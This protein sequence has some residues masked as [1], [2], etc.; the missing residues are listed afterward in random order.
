MRASKVV[1]VVVVVKGVVK[2]VCPP[3]TLGILSALAPGGQAPTAHNLKHVIGG[4]SASV[5]RIMS[6]WSVVARHA[7]VALSKVR[8]KFRT[9]ALEMHG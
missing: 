4:V 6:L 1:A 2:G 8:W 7:E 5:H 3:R 9:S